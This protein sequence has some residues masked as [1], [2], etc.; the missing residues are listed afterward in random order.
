MSESKEAAGASQ[1]LVA[2]DSS[3]IIKVTVKT[4]KQKEQFEVAQ[5]STIQEF[6]E[7]ISKRFQTPPELLALIFA[8]KI[9]KD[10]DT[11]SQ[12]GVHSGVSIHLVIRS[13]KSP[14]DGQ[15][16]QLA[17]TMENLLSELASSDLDMDTIN[18]NLFLLGFLI[19]VTGIHITGLDS[20]EVSDLVSRLQERDTTLHRLLSEIM[21][22]SSVQTI[23]LSA[24][25]ARDFIMSIP[26]VQQLVEQNPEIS[27]ILTN[28]HFIREILEACN[29]PAMMQ[30]MIRN[31]DR[32][33]NNLESIPGGYSA[34]EQLYREIEETM[35]DAGQT[36]LENNPFAS[37]DSNPSLNGTRLPACTENRRPLPNPWA[38]PSNGA[39]DNRNDYNG[40][41]GYNGA[42]HNFIVLNLGPAVRA[43]LPRSGS[44]QSMVQQLAENSE[45]M[46]NLENALTD[47]QGPAAQILLNN[48]HV[49]SDGSS[50]LQD[51]RAQ[52][53]PPEMENT[54]ISSLLRNP[55]ALQALLQVQLGLQT[56]SAE[57]PD[58]L[59]S[60]GDPDVELDLESMEESAKSS[61]S[62]EDVSLMSDRDDTE[63]QEEMDEQAP[64]TRFDRQMQQLSAMGFQDQNANLQALIDTEGEISA[65]VD[66]LTRTQSS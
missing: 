10:Q 2:T 64:Q 24:D 17:Q 52:Q 31:H 62:E 1:P 42:E 40:Q 63:S 60:L 32:A 55:R 61:E 15:A 29:S 46:H 8:G 45:L 4:L 38:P 53:L 43:V 33:L 19:G 59:L 9:L 35:L 56:L 16:E 22:D 30:E 37:P 66:I 18:N 14:Q 47:P 57:V 27:H 11:L 44:I 48:T 39:S 6:K 65:A 3:D 5:S 26:Q 36:Q 58:F 41:D 50:Q 51:E 7:E 13:Q 34:L 25:I 20:T 49:L 12:H 23:I 28:P 21:Q 54:E